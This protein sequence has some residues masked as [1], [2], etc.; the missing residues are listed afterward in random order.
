MNEDEEKIDLAKM[1][2]VD[3]PTGGCDR[4]VQM[5]SNRPCWGTPEDARRLIAAGYGSR[6]MADYWAV[7]RDGDALI[8][9][10]AIE[11]YESKH[12]PFWPRG[13]CTFLTPDGK[14]ELH[15]LGLKPTEGRI[16]DCRE[17]EDSKANGNG[18]H[19]AVADSWM[20][21]EAQALAAAWR[22]EFE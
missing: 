2:S 14:C 20:N 4:C 18:V 21:E 8:I 22:A 16:A 5:C 10:P 12:A 1:P 17:D 3:C 13:R 11:G 6:L 15:D 19:R 7:A 9:A